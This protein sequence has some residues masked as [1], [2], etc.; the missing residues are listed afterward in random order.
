MMAQAM[1]EAYIPPIIQNMHSQLRCSPLF[2][3]ANTSAK[4]E[5]TIGT[6]PPIL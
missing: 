4:Y 2:S 5:N 3:R 6:A 1:A